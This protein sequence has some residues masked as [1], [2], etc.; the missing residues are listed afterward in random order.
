MSRTCLGL[1]FGSAATSSGI[2]ADEV[3]NEVALAMADAEKP[4]E[5][6]EAGGLEHELRVDGDASLRLETA[7]KYDCAPGE[8]RLT[9]GGDPDSGDVDD[10]GVSGCGL[11]HGFMTE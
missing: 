10:D 4:Q 8:E 5:L 3:A 6:G 2:P 11:G 9:N 7:S 1:G